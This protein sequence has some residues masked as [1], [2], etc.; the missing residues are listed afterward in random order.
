MTE[1]AEQSYRHNIPEIIEAIPLKQLIEH[2]SSSNF[3]AY[4]KEFD[5]FLTSISRDISSIT[6][7]IGPEGGFTSEEADYLTIHGFSSV[8]L[9]RRILRAETAAIAA[10][11]ILD[12]LG[13]RHD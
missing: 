12:T 10:C 3:L 8:S 7:V 13:E 1:A 9:G 4:E 11:I 6:I 2:K 5:C